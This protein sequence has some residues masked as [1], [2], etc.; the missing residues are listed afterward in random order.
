MASQEPL[1]IMDLTQTTTDSSARAPEGAIVIDDS[2]ESTTSCRTAT[3]SP[4]AELLKFS[5]SQNSGR[6]YLHEARQGSSLHVNFDV[7]QILTEESANEL[8]QSQ[9][10]RT[11]SNQSLAVNFVDAKVRKGNT[12]VRSMPFFLVAAAHA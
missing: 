11:S 1:T 10:T 4:L 7:T 5:V 3:Q 8:D 2:D 9:V 12:K 6:V